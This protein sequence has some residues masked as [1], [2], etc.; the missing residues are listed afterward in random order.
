MVFYLYFICLVGFVTVGLSAMPE[1]GHVVSPGD[2]EL[3]CSLF[4]TAD[5]FASPVLLR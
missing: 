5:D 1:K 3:I 4:Q 2:T